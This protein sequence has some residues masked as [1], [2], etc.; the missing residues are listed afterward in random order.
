MLVVISGS[1]VWPRCPL[2]D[3]IENPRHSVAGRALWPERNALRPGWKGS[4]NR[5]KAAT[6]SQSYTAGFGELDWTAPQ[7]VSATDPRFEE[8]L[9][10]TPRPLD[11][12]DCLDRRSDDAD[13]PP[14]GALP[15]GVVGDGDTRGQQ[16]PERGSTIDHTADLQRRATDSKRPRVALTESVLPIRTDQVLGK[17]DHRRSKGTFLIFHADS[18]PHSSTDSGLVPIQDGART[19]ESAM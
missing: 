2:G 1:P 5:E 19:S 18:E 17:P 12:G 4:N 6:R 9:S 16:H 11:V 13:E 10:R 7:F 3:V 8:P 15:I 14:P